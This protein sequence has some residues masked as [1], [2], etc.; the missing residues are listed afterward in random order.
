MAGTSGR[1]QSGHGP[2]PREERGEGM[3]KDR[4]GN[5][6]QQSRGQKAKKGQVITVDG[7]Y[8][9]EPLREGHSSS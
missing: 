5:Q 9:E 4:K 3:G 2:E 7:L 8:R 1:V 6:V